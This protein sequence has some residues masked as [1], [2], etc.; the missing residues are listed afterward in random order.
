MPDGKEQWYIS[1]YTTVFLHLFILI[2]CILM[3][4]D[5]STY[6]MI[7]TTKKKLN[8]F[9]FLEKHFSFRNSNPQCPLDKEPLSE[10]EVFKDVCCQREVLTLICYCKNRKY[11]C[12]WKK[13][14]LY[15]EV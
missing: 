10:R 14:L 3:E 8:T 1:E 2:G 5:N 11:G 6:F 15:L 7:V 4:W 13:E 9:S 12:E